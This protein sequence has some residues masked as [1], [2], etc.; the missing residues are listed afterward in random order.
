[1]QNMGLGIA[2]ISPK[3]PLVAGAHVTLTYTYTADHPIDDTGYVKIVFRFASDFG[4]PQFTDFTEEN[5]CSVRTTGNCTIDPRWDPKGH[6][7][8]WGRSIYLKITR[9]FLD[10]GEKIV[11]VFGDTAKGSPGWR[12]QTFCED[13]FEFKTLVDPIATYEFK[14][15]PESPTVRIIPGRAIRALCVAPSQVMVGTRFRYHIK[16]E[17]RWGNP[18]R[19]P[20][21][22]LH[23][24][25]ETAGITHVEARDGRTGLMARSSPV[26]VVK[27]HAKLRP[28]W[29]DL[30]GQSEETLGTN[31]VED[32]FTFARDFGLLDAA[33][34]QGND[35]QVSDRFWRKLNR[36]TKAFYTPG[37]FVTFPGY[38]WSGNTPLGGDR[39]IYFSSEGG[40]IVHSDTDLLPG[41]HSDHPTERT[42]EALFAR[43]RSQKGPR[44]F[45]FAHV[46]GRYAD[47]RVHDPEIE[48]AV[49]VHSAWGTFE[50][51][52][53]D[54][55]RQGYRVG[56]CANSD[57]HKGRPGASYPGAGK[58]GAYGGLTCILAEKLDRKSLLKALKGRHFYA[59][60][61]NRCL[62]DVQLETPGRAPAMMGDVIRLGRGVPRLRVRIAGTAPI[63]CVE[64]RNGA[65]TVKILR[66]Y[67][68]EELGSRIKVTWSGAEVRGRARMVNW[69]GSLRVC[70]NTIRSFSPVN[71]LNPLR[72]PHQT[73][74][75]RIEWTSV[76]TGGL[77][78]LILLLNRP[79]AGDLEIRTQQRRVNCPIES[80][81]FRPRTWECGGLQKKI[82]VYRLPDR[83]DATTFS[84][85]LPLKKLHK[86]DNPLYVRVDQVDGHAAWSSPIYV[87]ANGG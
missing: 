8:P 68:K 23:P 22:V 73:H 30:H 74:R 80:I 47:M 55:L 52:V 86:G 83:L 34:H 78:G 50:W 84:F 77:A 76:T 41:Q 29:A 2:R 39:N 65:D 53:E 67:E 17:D 19:R 14:E 18:T 35:F 54:T 82:S 45:A 24:G 25:F 44:A 75:N 43:L 46:G 69:E 79:N 42:A 36:V 63:E 15:L 37:R 87:V 1:M 6:T 3:K 5:F 72:Q 62:L 33:A 9:G 71:F 21:R 85:D 58:F 20:V 11:L 16:T 31:T 28:C 56:I 81:G 51:L 27:E 26:R 60:T 32:Y 13:S 4:I 12:M 7:R 61:G 38:E 57:G 64:V 40:Q 49:E 10:K 66:P 59:T 48:I 70:R